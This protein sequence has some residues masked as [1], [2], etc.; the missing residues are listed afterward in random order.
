[1]EIRLAVAKDKKQILKY[2]CHIPQNKVGECIDNG[3]VDVLCDDDK[4]VGVLRYNLFWQTIPFLDLL[5]ID[6][7]YRGQGW[8]SKMMADWE[9]TMTRMGYPYVILSTQEDETARFFYEKIGYRRI[10][11]FLPP[12]QDADEIMYLKELKK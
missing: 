3:L 11:A 12:E 5:F 10:G 2:D 1:M 6:D 8:G 7:A 4:I 9:E